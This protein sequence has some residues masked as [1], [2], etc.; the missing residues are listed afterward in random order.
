MI[1]QYSREEIIQRVRH[2]QDEIQDMS[3]EELDKSLG[4]LQ[5][6]IIDPNLSDYIFWSEMTAEEIADKA[7]SYQPIIL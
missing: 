4:E 3:E 2:I 1:K 5:S 7:L 6:G